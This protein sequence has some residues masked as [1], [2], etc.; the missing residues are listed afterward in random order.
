ME[1][2]IRTVDDVLKLLDTLFEP[3]ADRWTAGGAAW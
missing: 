2:T 3:D 1:R